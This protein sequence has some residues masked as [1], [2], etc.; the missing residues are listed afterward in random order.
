MRS[1]A[2]CATRCI[3]YKSLNSIYKEQE[4]EQ[5]QEQQKILLWI[6]NNEDIFIIFIIDHSL[7]AASTLNFELINSNF[8]DFLLDF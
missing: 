2:L 4:Q 6:L 7:G 1:D 5:E 3:R 8:E